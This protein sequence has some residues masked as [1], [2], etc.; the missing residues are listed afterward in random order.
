MGVTMIDLRAVGL[1]ACLF[2]GHAQADWQYT[3]WGMTAG[4]IKDAAK[5]KQT[6]PISGEEV[7]RGARN[8]SAFNFKILFGFNTGRPRRLAAI[9]LMLEHATNDRCTQLGDA[10][11]AIYGKP[12]KDT[13]DEAGFSQPHNRWIDRKRS[14]AVTLV[15]RDKC[16][17]TYTPLGSSKIGG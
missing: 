10:L 4:E 2:A 3:K 16:S 9:Q 13:A 17:V 7:L 6:S 14:N 5:G 1:V 15:G 11:K 8:G 12:V